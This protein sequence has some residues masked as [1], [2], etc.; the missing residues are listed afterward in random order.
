MEVRVNTRV[1]QL[2]ETRDWEGVEQAARDLL[3]R[4]PNDVFALRALAQALEHQSAKEE[5]PKVW[6]RLA[7]L[8]DRPGPMEK[9]L[10]AH[11][12][13]QGDKESAIT[14]YRRALASFIR[15][16]DESEV[17]DLWLELCELDPSDLEW[18]LSM[19]ERLTG[20]RRKEQA[21]VLLQLL[22]PYYEE[23]GRWD[24]VLS[25]LRRAAA[26][27]PTDLSIRDAVIKALRAKH[28]GAP[29]LEHVIDHS[30]LRRAGAI[31]D[32][33]EWAERFIP[34][35]DGE[36][37]YH[38]DWGVGLVKELNLFSERVTIDFERK[39]N[40]EMSVDLAQDILDPLPHSDIRAAVI[41][42]PE[43][44]A[45]LVE[46][47]P[48]QIVKMALVSWGGKASTRQIKE[49]LLGAVIPE[50][51]WSRWWGN[52]SGL[53]RR[54]PYIGSTGAA[55]KTYVLRA[56]A[57]SADDEWLEQFDK[58]K[59]PA[60]KCD[61][62]QSYLRSVSS[63]D[64]SSDLLRRFAVSLSVLAKERRSLKVRVEMLMVLEDL[65]HVEASIDPPSV[66]D[67]SDIFKDR[68]KAL[69]VLLSLR[70]EEHQWRLAERVKTRY[71]D[72]WKEI[73]QIL[74]LDSSC[75]I[76]DRLAAD[77]RAEGMEN[78]L[79]ELA[80]KV[81][82][83]SRDYPKAFV[84][85]VEKALFQSD[86]A[87]PLG[88]EGPV[89][90]E[91]L[92]SLVDFLTDRAKRVEKDEAEDL[93][94]SA[95]AVRSLIKRED[96]GILQ[97]LLETMDRSV[98]ASLYKRASGNAGL[99]VRARE[100]I[101][102]R[103]LG[104]YPGLFAAVDE[105]TGKSEQFL[106][107]RRSL[108]TKRDRLRHIVE[109]ELP[110]VTDEIE[111]ARKQGDLS[112]NAEYHAARDKQKT[113]SGEAG[114]LQEQ[115]RK[116]RPV[117]L[118]EIEADRVRFGIRLRLNGGDGQEED[119][120]VLGPWESDPSQNILSYQAPFISCF[121]G[122]REGEVVEVSLPNRSGSFTITSVEPLSA[123]LVSHYNY[124]PE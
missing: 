20:A 16:R 104:R 119:I 25:I 18:F 98:A 8:E 51:Q 42:E 17:E 10:G 72:E 74:I 11:Y 38:P 83:D 68:S 36:A 87:V 118:E 86:D 15:A 39:K 24:D 53:L 58:K 62:V 4:E 28:A 26:F 100:R 105:E 55:S 64:R 112:E 22:V 75:L 61:V 99:D 60:D 107:T 94:R 67:Y 77:L 110:R 80:R 43:R 27:A 3:K 79:E 45:E 40:H 54:D 90:F 111:E 57:G 69:D 35:S 96:F 47:D 66:E 30:G 9:S 6:R 113:L 82:H 117:D 33:L 102:R 52:V 12:L 65:S 81:T 46:K 114:D 76:R 44:V 92:L 21:G 120:I 37:C 106:C 124:L 14:W 85:F 49:R 1:N 48:V 122:K 29:A 97:N 34:F 56:E 13:E 103:I 32:S 23:H 84:W 50:K 108:D 59:N 88:I 5:L 63:S 7:D 89:L 91:R 2:R 101:T 41:R 109:I 115:L 71:P 70:R 31:L 116:A 78:V 123:E 95:A 121:S 73:C 19:S 93:R